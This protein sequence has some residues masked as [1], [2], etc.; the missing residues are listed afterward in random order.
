MECYT[1]SGTFCDTWLFRKALSNTK[2]PH[3]ESGNRT[4]HWLPVLY[5]Q[6]QFQKPSPLA[7]TNSC[8]S[9]MEESLCIAVWRILEGNAPKIEWVPEAVSLCQ[10]RAWGGAC[11]TG[12][13]EQ[14][15]SNASDTI[16]AP[17][18]KPG[19][20]CHSKTAT[21]GVQHTNK[22]GLH[23]EKHSHRYVHSYLWNWTKDSLSNDKKEK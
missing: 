21:H 10:Y 1:S 23:S 19:E 20:W 2:F 22:P 8:V 15:R 17:V 5:N 3:P 6:L 13:G 4:T 9:S 12:Q 11:S 14:H 16:M 18:R 7:K